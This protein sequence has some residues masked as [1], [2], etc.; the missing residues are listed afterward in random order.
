MAV[1]PLGGTTPCT[2]PRL[3]LQVLIVANGSSSSW[4]AAQLGLAALMYASL[5]QPAIVLP[6]FLVI[7]AVVCVFAVPASHG[8]W[9]QSAAPGE[10]L[11]K[12]D[13]LRE[14]AAAPSSRGPLSAGPRPSPS[15]AAPSSQGPPSTGSGSPSGS[16]DQEFAG[17]PQYE[18][19]GQTGSSFT[20]RNTPQSAG[21]HQY[22]VLGQAGPSFT[23]SETPVLLPSEFLMTGSDVMEVGG[24]GM[25][26][27]DLIEVS[28][29][30]G[31]TATD[32]P[33]GTRW[34][35]RLLFV[36]P[37]R[38]LLLIPRIPG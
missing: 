10:R 35:R 26:A 37:L 28:A 3:A 33:V 2:D 6:Q 5:A 19:P 4:T 38:L 30:M 27:T 31:M 8:C 9:R 14:G 7:G 20:G 12:G 32:L 23:G 34:G 16:A 25:T 29:G 13:H 21:V 1:Q 24:G 22:E 11:D 15:G 18:D 17:V 36:I